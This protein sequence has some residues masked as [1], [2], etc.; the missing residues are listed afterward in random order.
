MKMDKCMALVHIKLFQQVEHTQGTS[1]EARKKAMENA[2]MKMGM[3]TKV[4]GRAEDFMARELSL[5]QM[6]S[7]QQEIGTKIRDMENKY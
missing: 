1:I 7:L 5:Q 4:S 2:P 6:E 3:C